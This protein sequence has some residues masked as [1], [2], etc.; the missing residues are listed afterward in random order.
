M[1]KEKEATAAKRQRKRDPFD[2]VRALG[3]ALPGVEEGTMF[4]TP[5]LR[6]RGR[7]F[8]CIAS[9]KSAEP[10]TLVVCIDFDSRDELIAAEPETY[11]LTDHYVG[12]PSVLVRLS[13]IRRDALEDL[14]QMA[15]RGAMN[16][17]SRRAARRPPRRAARR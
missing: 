4:G 3:L 1:K 7:M 5:A 9:H 16:K 10:D 15:W 8:S 11:Y 14:L 17:A 2:P 12:Y 6:V 13:R